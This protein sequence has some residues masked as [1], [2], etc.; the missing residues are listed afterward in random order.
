MKKKTPLPKNKN[1]TPK[2][3]VKGWRDEHLFT[4]WEICRNGGTDRMIRDV[5]GISGATLTAWMRDVPL[6][7]EGMQRARELLESS[8][9]ERFFEYIH[10]H[11][12]A[13]LR[14]LWETMK[15]NV[16]DKDKLG[17]GLARNMELVA[18]EPVINQQHLF[19]HAYASSFFNA[20]A[21]VRVLG[22]SVRKLEVWQKDAG[23]RRL[24]EEVNFHKKG[25]FQNAL[26]GLVEKGDPRAI[27]F[28]NERVNR[29]E[30]GRRI[31]LEI[32]GKVEV[33]HQ[34][35]MIMMKDVADRLSFDTRQEL[36]EVFRAI[37]AE[38]AAEALGD[39]T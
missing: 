19:L 2:P 10:G 18:A 16:E 7:A 27:L 6:L 32:S 29:E 14:A 37:E 24:L 21:A 22:I 5:L 31:G 34:H 26:M 38:N 3:H 15:R 8:A 1:S 36:L 13:D 28:A 20:S 39:G 23:F 17:G 9:V 11:L 33:E 35:K 12:P 30:Y 25:Y 4:I